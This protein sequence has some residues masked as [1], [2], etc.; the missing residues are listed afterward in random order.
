M[1]ARCRRAQAQALPALLWPR[2]VHCVG[3]ALS[4]QGVR[5]PLMLVRPPVALVPLLAGINIDAL[6]LGASAAFLLLRFPDRAAATA[7]LIGAGCSA[8]PAFTM[9]RKP[10]A[11]PHGVAR[12]PSDVGS[13]YAALLRRDEHIGAHDCGSCCDVRIGPKHMVPAE[14]P[15]TPQPHHAPIAPM[16]SAVISRQRAAMR[17]PVL[18]AAPSEATAAAQA[19]SGC[20]SARDAGHDVRRRRCQ[21]CG[22]RCSPERVSDTSA[23][24]AEVAVAARASAASTSPCRRA[25]PRH[26]VGLVHSLAQMRA[27]PLFMLSTTPPV[28]TRSSA[29]SPS[30]RSSSSWSTPQG[31]GQ[32]SSAMPLAGV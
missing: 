7:E 25:A 8:M 31:T 30:S 19:A 24:A 29:S 15:V 22:W 5:V 16:S 6:G 1:C 17:L 23:A 21:L 13:V 20:G 32:D 27:T 12:T 4:V 2:A 26:I 28:P 9:L 10:H 11:R 14:V 3:S 18:A